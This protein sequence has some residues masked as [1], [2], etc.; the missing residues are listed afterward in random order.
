MFPDFKLSKNILYTKYKL[1][2][3]FKKGLQTLHSGNSEAS[4]II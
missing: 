3:I 1:A 2:I 4:P